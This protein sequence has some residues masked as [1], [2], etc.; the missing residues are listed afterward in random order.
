MKRALFALALVLDTVS[1]ARASGQTLYAA[2]GSNGAAGKLYT[3][4]PAT[5]ASTLVGSTTIGASAIGL[6]GLAFHPV[7]GF[8]YGATSNA[9]GVPNPRSLVTI[10][11]TTGA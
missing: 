10:N 7:T 6:T 9:T 5:A 8:L 11:P 2:T 4:D 3:V 1:S